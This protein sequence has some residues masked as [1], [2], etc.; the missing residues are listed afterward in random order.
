MRILKS[1]LVTEPIISSPNVSFPNKGHFDSRQYEIG[2][3]LT[4]VIEG[5]EKV[6]S[7]YLR[8]LNDDKC[9]ANHPGLK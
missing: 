6:I 7:Y 2:G 8:Q 5:S 1:L 3:I 4:H 9:G